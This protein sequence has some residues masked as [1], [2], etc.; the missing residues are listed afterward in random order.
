MDHILTNK[1]L[2]LFAGR[3][4]LVARLVAKR[5]LGRL[6]Y[7]VIV[8][9]PHELDSI[10]NRCV[11]G[12][13]HISKNALGRGDNDRVGLA[14]TATARGGSRGGRH[15]HARRLAVLGHTFCLESD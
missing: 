11:E 7:C 14:V 9:T 10:A 12:K 3:E 15:V 1:R 6:G 8:G 13:R 4:G 2:V 5:K